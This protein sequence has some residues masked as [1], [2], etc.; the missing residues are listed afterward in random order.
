MRI[1]PGMTI[2]SLLVLLAMADGADDQP[3][4]VKAED[5]RQHAGKK[6]AV[7][8]E[9]KASKYSQKRKTVYLDSTDNFRDEKNLGIAIS[10]P[11]IND[12]KQKRQ[13]DAP[14]DYYRG[15]SI[16]VEGVVVIEEERTYIKVDTAEQLDLAR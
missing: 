8:F 11:G 2:L 3:P 14:A 5:A 13:V 7:V 10:E 16:R 15:R 1:R 4:L 6:I 9:V 12:L